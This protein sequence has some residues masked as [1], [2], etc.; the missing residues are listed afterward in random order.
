MQK[1]STLPFNSDSPS[2]PFD[3][4]TK[5]YIEVDSK[6]AKLYTLLLKHI[7]ENGLDASS[8]S[9][10]VIPAANKKKS[11]ARSC[12]DSSSAITTTKGSEAKRISLKIGLGVFEFFD[13]KN[14][15]LFAIHQTIGD[16]IGTNCGAELY[17]SL[18]VFTDE[19]VDE[20]ALFFSELIEISEKAEAG[21]VQFYSWHIK[22]QYWQEGAKCRSRPLESV[23]LPEETKSQLIGDIT[24]FL[25][26]DA[27]EFYTLHGIPYRRSY[28]LYGVP[29]AGKTSLI[30]ALAG[31]YNRSISYLQPTHP[32][33]TDDSLR[34][35][36][37]DLPEDTIVVLE[38]ID[39]LF[40]KDRSTKNPKSNLTFSGLL[41]A[42]DGIGSPNGQI[43]ILTTNLRDQLDAALIRKGRVDYQV[44][45]DYAADEQILKM[46]TSFYPDAADR[47]DEFCALVREKLQ[48]EG[49]ATS[50]LQHYFVMQMR[51]SAEEALANIDC[52]VEDWME[53]KAEE[54]AAK[55]KAEE[56]EKEE[57]EKSSNDEEGSQEVATKDQAPKKKS[58]SKKEQEEAEEEKGAP[59][60]DKVHHIH[61]H[62][63]TD[64]LQSNVKS[65]QLVVSV[66]P[67]SSEEASKS[68]SVVCN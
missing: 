23:I 44:K 51:S 54:D 37:T 45:F 49:I 14:T 41:N 17:K 66:V 1:T 32:D 6:N 67:P 63:H 12:C 25:S 24:S 59:E 11:R 35:A 57:G 34:K 56:D 28:L 16:P 43:Y 65:D 5:R 50:G 55:K 26:P 3:P 42:L 15:K 31:H 60:N 48:G 20:L 40:A 38:D 30:Q 58:L 39:S 29:G 53:R 2:L 47:A 8:F 19:S 9:A 64:I 22:Y 13:L 52:I 36:V 61:L 4:L 21:M 18:V 62:V 33:M 10:D 46:W 68:S 7:A 27:R